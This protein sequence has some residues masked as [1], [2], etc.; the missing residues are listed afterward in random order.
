MRADSPASTREESRLSPRFSRGG[1]SHLLQLKRNPEIPATSWK[2][3][4]F[5]LNLR[6]GLNPLQWLEWNLEFPLTTRREVWFPCCT[7]R[8]SPSSLSQLNRRPN[9]PFTTQEESGVPCHKTRWGLTL[10]L[11]LDRS[12]QIPVTTGE[13]PWV[14]HLNSRWGPI[15]LQWLE[16]NPEFPVTTWEVPVFPTSFLNEGRFPCFNSRG[17]LTLPKHLKRRP[18]SPIAT[19]EDPQGSCLKLKGQWVS[20]QLEIKPDSLQWLEWSPEFPLTAWRE[21]L[22]PCCTSRKAWVPC[23]NLTGC[24]TPLLQLE[25]KV[26]FHA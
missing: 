26:E 24:L 11:K 4:E 14:S 20:P 23:L 1:L 22:F 17:I 7:S 13:V 16:R 2:A 6:E 10:L 21:V 9:T 18:L 15:P 12:P 19:Q 25:R 8:K 5:P 3:T